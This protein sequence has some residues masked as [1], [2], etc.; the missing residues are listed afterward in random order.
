[1]H[2]GILR[3]SNRA[4][5]VGIRKVLGASV[6]NIFYLLAS[7]FTKWIILSSL[8]A[9]PLAYYFMNQWL[10]NFAYRTSF[11]LFSFILSGVIALLVA[12]MTVSFQGL[13]TALSNPV[14]SLRYE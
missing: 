11:S 14:T 5:E 9:W 1:L 7:E 4:K 10:E 13:K 6:F 2:D 8:I 12:L 3:T